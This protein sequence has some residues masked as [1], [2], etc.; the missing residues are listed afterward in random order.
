MFRLR[1][2][3]SEQE[4]DRGQRF[5][6]AQA[7]FGA[8]LDGI[9][10]GGFLAAF[11]LALGA[12]NFQIGVIATLPLAAQSFQIPAVFLV[13]R[14]RQRK[15]VAVIAYLVAQSV[16]IPIALIPFLL[17][18]PSGGAVT[19]LLAFLA[20]RGIAN[21][22]VNA[23]WFSWVRDL[24]PQPVLGGFFS[25]RQRWST[26]AAAA[27]G[28]SAA[29]LIQLWQTR[30]VPDQPILGYAFAFAA[31]AV[32]FGWS[33]LACMMRVP[34]PQMHVPEG[35]RPG[36]LGVLAAPLKDENFRHLLTFLFLWNFAI[37]LAVPFFAVYM[38]RE[39]GVPLPVVIM[40]TVLSQV[41]TV[42][43]S[44]VWG[45]MSDKVG[46]KAV[47]SLG[48]S[49]YLAVI[50]G[51][52][53]T[54]RPGPHILT[55]PLLAGLHVFAGVAASSVGLTDM[56][57]RMKLAPKEHPGAYLT[58]ASLAISMGGGLGPLAG[59]L[60]A[61]FFSGHQLNLTLQ[62]ID[63][64]R[65]IQ[66][67]V[68]KMAGFDFLFILAFILGLIVLNILATIREE[69]EV[70]RQVVLDQLTAQ[71]R[72]G[73]QAVTSVPWV[74]AVVQ[75]PYHFLRRVPGADVALGVTAYQVA[76]SVRAAAAAASHGGTVADELAQRIGQTLTEIVEESQELG[77]AGP[78]LARN[79]TRG[80]LHLAGEVSAD[81]GQLVTG[82]VI[83]V[84]NALSKTSADVR[85]AVHSAAYGAVV[86][87]G[88]VGADVV[89]AA[90]HSI[91]AAREA[92]RRLGQGEDEFAAEAIRGALDASETLAPDAARRLRSALEDRQP[93][94]PSEDH[95]PNGGGQQ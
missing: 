2:V 86:G 26:A 27:A 33:G 49:L 8:A 69:G 50:L 4:R 32:F 20:F 10:S 19:M 54:G 93:K 28:L 92:A 48:A 62:W 59:G 72:T 66:L 31:G 24:V 83:G 9:T 38:L 74:G 7:A 64:G 88:E 46:S 13:E 43:F 73:F 18:Y 82:A 68:I 47:L 39:L 57:L 6:V 14:L 81:L 25:L 87:A 70:D 40:L 17:S 94:Q 37:N 61:D 89:Q 15:G 36:F 52:T 11:A 53:F 51:W 77:S 3:L 34:E 71:A 12:S 90:I 22:F 95:F 55:L 76:A 78:D 45:P 56:T 16:W 41:S 21:A 79:S 91:E 5:S 65:T 42:V 58:V 23:S 85:E 67:P 75:L 63:P 30:A 44:R 1:E 29:W 35:P 60:L 84:V 80:A